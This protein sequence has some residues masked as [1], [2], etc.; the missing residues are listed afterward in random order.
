MR[1][2]RYSNSEACA[3]GL[4]RIAAIY[5]I[6]EEIREQRLPGEAACIVSHSQQARR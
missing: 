4:P 5:A 6:E 2:E 1:G 3:R